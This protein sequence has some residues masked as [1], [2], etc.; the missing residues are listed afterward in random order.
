M[1]EHLFC[2]PE[3]KAAGLEK[4]VFGTAFAKNDYL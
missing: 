2:F 4:N 1:R 3:R